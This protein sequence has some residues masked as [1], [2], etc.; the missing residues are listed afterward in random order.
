MDHF[1]ALINM[2]GVQNNSKVYTF[3][4]PF[5]DLTCTTFRS[6][7]NLSFYWNRFPQ[8]RFRM[9]TNCTRF[10]FKYSKRKWTY[11]RVQQKWQRYQNVL[12]PVTLLVH[13]ILLTLHI[14]KV[15]EN[16]RVPT[17]W[18]KRRAWPLL[19]PISAM[20]S[21]KEV[22]LRRARLALRW[23]TVSTFNSRCQAFTSVSNQPA[24]QGQLSLPSLRG[25]KMRIS[26]RWE[27]KGRYG[28]FR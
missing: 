27:G 2:F 17:F 14:W 24:T 9:T 4:F 23:A 15:G 12:F 6:D 18:G 1:G 21:I 22:N 25:R 5:T 3:H 19:L 7:F 28:S 11:K 26:C 10:K 20:A 13:C 8:T 16:I